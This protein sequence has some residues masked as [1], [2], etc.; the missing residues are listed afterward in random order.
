M[1]V[2]VAVAAPRS[3][4]EPRRARA[5]KSVS[6]EIFRNRRAS[7]GRSV[8]YRFGASRENA[9]AYENVRQDRQSLQTDP[10]GYADDLNLYM[11]VRNDPLNT[12]DPS[13]RVPFLVPVFACVANAACRG[14]VGAVAGAVIGAGASVVR[15]ATDGEPGIDAGRVGID[16]AKGAAIS[17]VGFA[18]A[19]PEAGFGAASVIGSAATSTAVEALDR[20]ASGHDTENTAQGAA[21]AGAASLAA[22]ALISNPLTSAVAGQVIQPIIET[23][24]ENHKEEGER[25]PIRS[26]TN[27]QCTVWPNRC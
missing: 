9:Y 17:G 2:V 7:Q 1:A 21:T 22:D 24:V 5:P 3:T 6:T 8:A 10:I 16:A 18:L 11:Y 27:P 26:A 19:N 15:Q 14:A 25:P 20:G 12:I 23:T 13:G 4:S